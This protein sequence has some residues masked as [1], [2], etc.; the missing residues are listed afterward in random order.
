M[1]TYTCILCDLPFEFET[2]PGVYDG[3]YIGSW[4]VEICSRCL[5]SNWDGVPLKHHPRPLI[6]VISIG[7]ILLLY[8]MWRL[9]N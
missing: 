8:W 7:G 5:R 6:G 4:G 3:P 9:A 1:A 2:R